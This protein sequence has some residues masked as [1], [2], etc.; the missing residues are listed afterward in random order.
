MMLGRPRGPIAAL[1]GGGRL[2]NERSDAADPR[3]PASSIAT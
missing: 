1:R 3:R 2:A